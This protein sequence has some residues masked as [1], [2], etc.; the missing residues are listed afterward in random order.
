M[1]G[2]NPLPAVPARAILA[3]VYHLE[4]NSED[5]AMLF[6][7]LVGEAGVIGILCFLAIIWWLIRIETDIR[8]YSSGKA[9]AVISIQSAL[10]FSFVASFLIRSAGYF[11]GGVLLLVVAIAASVRW[12]KN[13]NRRI[14]R[15]LVMSGR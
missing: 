7:K 5:G 6:G 14:T 4:L 10:M 11:S 13:R 2:C 3:N 12:R 15:S 9:T 8:K 1:M